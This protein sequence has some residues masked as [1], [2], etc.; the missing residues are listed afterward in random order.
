MAKK[1]TVVEDDEDASLMLSKVLSDA[2]YTVESFAEGSSIVENRFAVPDMF[3]LDNFMPAIHGIA[4]CK[5]LKLQAITKS[6]PVI[7]IS[8]N[9]QIQQKAT[10]AGAVFFLGK[11]FHSH[12]LLNLVEIVLGDKP[13]N[14]S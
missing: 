13:S 9:K 4:L 3:I 14:N 2:G 1:I 6:I 10:N 5:Y 7:I 8:A 12:D 11:P